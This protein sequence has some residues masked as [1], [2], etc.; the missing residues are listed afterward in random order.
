MVTLAHVLLCA[1]IL[2]IKEMQHLMKAQNLEAAN[3]QDSRSQQD[4]C[5]GN[6]EKDDKGGI[7]LLDEHEK[8][9]TA[10]AVT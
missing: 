8:I 1:V 3:E 10:V 5:A 2:C 9:I 6:G 4:A 7:H